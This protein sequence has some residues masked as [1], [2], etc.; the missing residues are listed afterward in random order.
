[1]STRPSMRDSMPAASTRSPPMFTSPTTT[2]STLDHSTPSGPGPSRHARY[3]SSASLLSVP[4]ARHEFSRR[5]SAV[6]NSTT[7]RGSGG[8]S[9]PRNPARSGEPSANLNDADWAS[10]EA[11]EVFRRLP[12]NDVKKVE[13]RLRADALNKQSELRAMVGTRYRDLLTSASQ[14][15]SLHSSSLHL[16]DSL[17]AVAQACA[18]PADVPSSGTSAGD[19]QPGE[20]DDV[21]TLSRLPVAAHMK[22]LLDTP[23]TLYAFLSHHAYLSAAFLWLVARVVKEGLTSMPGEL[24]APYL[25][26]LQKQW[27]TLLPF[28]NQITQ[29][30]TASLK[31]RE[32]LDSKTLSETLLA[33]ILLENLPLGDALDLFLAQRLKSLREALAHTGVSSP[34]TLLDSHTRR[35]RDSRVLAAAAVREAIHSR[36]AIAKVLADAAQS[37][38]ATI[39]LVTA[40]FGE[41]RRLDGDASLIA[42]MI[43]AVQ[44]GEAAPPQAPLLPHRQS[45][46]HRR[47]SRLA[48]ISL[49]L[50]RANSHGRSPP[51]S[52]GQIIEHLPSSQILLRYLP[53]S[54]TGFTPFITS[55]AN[56]AVADKISAWQKSAIAVLTETAP[57]WLRDLQSVADLWHVRSTL[58]SLLADADFGAQ[59]AEALEAEWGARVTQLWET[60]LAALL[61]SAEVAVHDAAER[62]RLEPTAAAD[63]LCPESWAFSDMAFPTAPLHVT[64]HTTTFTSFV[65]AL[66][67]RGVRR[68]PLLDSVLLAFEDAA[69]DLKADM[70]GLPSGLWVDYRAKAQG[71]L[72]DLVNV[73]A[74]LLESVGAARGDGKDGVEAELFVGRVALY[75]AKSSPFL[76]DVVGEAVVDL[77]GTRQALVD[78]H[79]R[80]TEHWQRRAIIEAKALL[81]PIF[82]PLLGEQEIQLSWQGPQPTA[83]SH[84]VLVALTS[85]VQAVKQVGM[86]PTARLSVGTD[87][88][89]AFVDDVK[90]MEEWKAMDGAAAVQA[91]VD[92][93][94]LEVLLGN[95]ADNDPAIQKLLAKAPADLPSSFAT[96]LPGILTDH[97]R[98]TQLILAPLLAHLPS[99]DADGKRDRNAALLRLGQPAAGRPGSAAEFKSPL[100][101][102]RIGKRFGL[103]SVVA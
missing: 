103:L 12:V 23:E 40:V 27:D 71:M 39:D 47:T 48:S 11:D 101:V 22:L 29:R 76:V 6:S 84:A 31:P 91:A 54:I 10:M 83:P 42:D 61:Q 32:K 18:T 28:R 88:L 15:T 90:N 35:R 58:R 79:A 33:I 21:D 46:Q 37:M 25:P 14:I 5:V 55:S 77:E 9:T 72:D 81:A 70:R 2:F 97:L 3:N 8:V 49:T 100:A 7:R 69:T 44:E 96:D 94:F 66:K 4:P 92:L 34:K 60:K 41:R 36:E 30:A 82:D 24:K 62:M 38:L 51:V 16:S 78:F 75:L 43:K 53:S 74:R 80:S 67:K 64:A 50:P 63:E 95:A 85:L 99:A 87:L 56:P 89:T 59:I 73:L 65:S 102:A 57:A 68:S 52:A 45:S 1:M 19:K 26:L 98:R 20:A 13:A 17:K 86:P 93:G